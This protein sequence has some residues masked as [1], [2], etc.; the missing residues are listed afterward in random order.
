[1]QLSDLTSLAYSGAAAYL[2]RPDVAQPLL[3]GQWRHMTLLRLGMQKVAE[4][5]QGKCSVL[6]YLLSPAQKA[7]SEAEQEL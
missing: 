7:V 4:S 3:V 5:N 1:M 6:D 2:V